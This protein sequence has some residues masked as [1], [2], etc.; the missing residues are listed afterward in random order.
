MTFLISIITFLITSGLHPFHVTVCEI[1]HDPDTKALQVSQRMFLDDLEQTLD[2][3]YHVRIDIMN[4]EN[5]QLRDSLIQDYVLT[6]LTITVDGK[7]RKRDYIGHEIEDDV[8]WCYI[9]YH[10]VKKLE[11]V[12]VTNTVFFDVYD[13]QST[14][15][16]VKYNDETKSKRLTRLKPTEHFEFQ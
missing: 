2:K 5:K 6:H 4:P 11:T 16:H 12:D 8:M 15:V 14:I 13:D 9:E 7:P 10:G 3:T 1:E